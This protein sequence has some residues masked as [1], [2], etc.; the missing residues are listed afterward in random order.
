L[1]I[2]NMVEVQTYDCTKYDL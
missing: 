1:I 2:Q